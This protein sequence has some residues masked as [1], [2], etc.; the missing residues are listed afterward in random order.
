MAEAQRLGGWMTRF[1]RCIDAEAGA[2]VSKKVIIKTEQFDGTSNYAQK[3]EWIR[4]AVQRLEKEAGKATAIKVM[5]ACGMKCCGPT[6]HR[7]FLA[8]E[9]QPPVPDDGRG[10]ARN[11]LRSLNTTPRF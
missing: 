11:G 8:P 1:K 9:K 5:Q 4:K 3:A 6:R 10:D 2:A 7:P